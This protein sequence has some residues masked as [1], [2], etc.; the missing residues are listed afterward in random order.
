M[1]MRVLCALL[2]SLSYVFVIGLCSNDVLTDFRGSHSLIRL[3]F[4]L[5]PFFQDIIPNDIVTILIHLWF[6][7]FLL[8]NIAS[9]CFSFSFLS[10]TT[11]E[12]PDL[13]ASS[14]IV[15]T[16]FLI[17]Y[18]LIA[19]ILLVTVLKLLSLWINIKQRCWCL[20]VFFVLTD[21]VF[22][23]LF[24]LPGYV[25]NWNFWLSLSFPI[26]IKL[27][28]VASLDFPSTTQFWEIHYLL[29]HSFDASHHRNKLVVENLSILFYFALLELNSELLQSFCY[30]FLA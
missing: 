25:I 24:E 30:S 23:T 29:H 27:N 21:S 13:V 8:L 15:S 11:N 19:L 22:L 26:F 16:F 5:T 18:I 14:L 17:F 9:I 2:S 10:S 28:Q 3:L 20:L 7:E 12:I 6:W 4:V 1:I